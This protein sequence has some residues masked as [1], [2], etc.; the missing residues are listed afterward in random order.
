MPEP[1][2][3]PEPQEEELFVPQIQDDGEDFVESKNPTT[4]SPSPP[5]RKVKRK[6][7]KKTFARPDGEMIYKSY[8]KKRHKKHNLKWQRRYFVLY[9]ES[10]LYYDNE[11]EVDSDE[12]KGK[13]ELSTFIKVKFFLSI[14]G[15]HM[16]TI[17]LENKSI[18]LQAE[19]VQHWNT[20]FNIF[21]KLLTID[22]VEK[23]DV[24]PSP[25]K[26]TH[27]RPK[28]KILFSSYLKKRHKKNHTVW[29]N[30]FFVL[31]E[32]ALLYYDKEHQR[33]TDVAKGRIN[34]QD[35]NKATFGGEDNR[36]LELVCTGGKV[37]V[38]QAPSRNEMLRWQEHFITSLGVDKVEKSDEEKATYDTE[39]IYSGY[40]KKRSPK[41]KY[42]WQ[43]RYYVL[44]AESFSYYEDD[45]YQTKKG[46][47]SLRDIKTAILHGDEC[48]SINIVLA[49]KT[50]ELTAPSATDATR[51]IN[52]LEQ[53]IGGDHTERVANE[54][55]LLARQQSVANLGPVTAAKTP[56]IHSGSL[57][58][59]S[60]KNKLVWQGR[61]YV[62]HQD[63]L[64]YYESEMDRQSNKNGI[65]GENKCDDI[66]MVTLHG[67]GGRNLDVD[68]GT[69]VVELMAS[70]PQDA[71]KWF[72]AFV[73]VLGSERTTRALLNKG[74]R[75]QNDIQAPKTPHSPSILPP[76]VSD[77]KE[78]FPSDIPETHCDF[79]YVTKEG[80]LKKE[81]P[82]TMLG[83]TTF[84]KR[85][86]ALEERGKR[87]RLCYWKNEKDKNNKKECLG[88]MGLTSIINVKPFEDSSHTHFLMIHMNGVRQRIFVLQT[89]DKDTCME[90]LQAIGPAM[91]KAHRSQN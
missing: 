62:L 64:L 40:L 15:D 8:L 52:H 34:A 69:K 79:K 18:D 59:R 20:W 72:A 27:A 21:K 50:H 44:S 57:K 67:E 35:I 54:D 4:D 13:L 87:G 91:Q 47:I 5:K 12:A 17:Q 49:A 77:G 89:K 23:N 84:Q 37:V 11:F 2:S 74:H 85:Y 78:E 16:I 24:L 1:K 31:Y 28:E 48:K 71:E 90:W 61:F 65:K 46:E 9:R 58:K 30:R 45:T 83:L 25:Q 70:K 39:I 43:S 36:F 51:W 68:I 75:T 19:K 56:V 14:V 42:V 26:A 76:Q 81:A 88:A 86:F 38:L 3:E 22:R 55:K 80:I 10:I 60:P 66:K 29:Q 41:N 7:G 73:K 53:L 63:S 32:L 33:E 6:K 82:K